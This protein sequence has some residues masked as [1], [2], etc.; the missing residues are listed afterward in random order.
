[1]VSLFSSS[2]GFKLQD[3]RANIHSSWSRGLSYTTTW[4]ERIGIPTEDKEDKKD[5]NN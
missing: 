1:M 2:L 5:I 4:L 3:T